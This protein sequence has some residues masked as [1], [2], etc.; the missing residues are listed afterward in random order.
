VAA[1]IA[2]ARLHAHLK[3]VDASRQLLLSRLV[4]AQ[5][6][7]RRRIASDVH[8][9]S[10]QV[11]TAAYM[12]LQMLASK[13]SEPEELEGLQRLERTL[14]GAIS[15]L[16][17]LL[18]ELRPPALEREGLVPALQAYLHQAFADL[19][20]HC[21]VTGE[22]DAEPPVEVRTILYRVAQEALTNVRKHARASTV[23]VSVRRVGGGVEVRVRDDG[24]G[25]VP[26]PAVDPQPG[27][28]G[29]TNMHERSEIA[30]GWCRIDSAPGRGTTV[31]AWI[32][33]PEAGT[34]A[35]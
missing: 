17:T 16:R 3:E 34:S 5:E 13:V 1:A 23:E 26:E 24:V 31:A 8:D 14:Q 29:L 11:M 15:R 12:R 19:P 10:V 7:E 30:G 21:R 4:S 25:F 6:E 2:N 20:I 32:P 27:H 22:L 35:A 33:L 18:F 28:L 9:D